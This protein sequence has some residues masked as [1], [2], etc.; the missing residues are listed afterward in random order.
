MKGDVLCSVCRE[1]V[2][3]AVSAWCR[4]EEAAKRLLPAAASD[5]YSK[6]ERLALEYKAAF[7]G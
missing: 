1:A 6:L 4:I 3:R 2:S 5:D 7:G